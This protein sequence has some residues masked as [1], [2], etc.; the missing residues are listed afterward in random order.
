MSNFDQVINEAIR[1]TEL[2]SIRCNYMENKPYDKNKL[3]TENVLMSEANGW[4]SFANQFL[5]SIFDENSQEIA[6][7]EK[8]WQDRM[9]IHSLMGTSHKTHLEDTKDALA[10]LYKLKLIYETN[11]IPVSKNS[12]YELFICHASEDKIDFV[13]PLVEELKKINVC[14]WY[15]EY[16]LTVGDSLR[17][18]ID[19]GLKESKFGVVVLSKAFFSKNWTQYELNGLIAREMQGYKVVLPI[20]YG[21][22][23]KDI[24]NYS[25]ALA[26]KLSIDSS[27]K[28]MTE[29]AKE[30]KKAIEKSK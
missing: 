16:E 4:M 9:Q 19:N 13:I 14:V 29:I 11:I 6:T 7:W 28:G 10:I 26:D 1:L 24:L 2:F 27:K 18:T 23:I 30:L 22:S 17:R 8:F 25:P 5:L 21:V 12:E 3:K 15:D 20:W